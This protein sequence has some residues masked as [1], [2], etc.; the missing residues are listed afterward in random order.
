M[1]RASEGSGRSHRKYPPPPSPPGQARIK[2]MK[3]SKSQ[4]NL[5]IF[6]SFLYCE[7]GRFDEAHWFSYILKNLV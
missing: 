5:I 2:E 6:V 1:L 4:R 3:D 7:L